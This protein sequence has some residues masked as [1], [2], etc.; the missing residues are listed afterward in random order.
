MKELIEKTIAKLNE[1]FGRRIIRRASELKDPGKISTGSLS[2]D[3]AIGGGYPRARIAEIHGRPASFKT[4]MALKVVKEFQEREEKV[5]FIDSEASLNLVWAK[6]LGVDDSRLL[7]VKPGT[8]EEGLDIME[9][10][11]RT[12]EIGLVVIDTINGLIPRAILEKSTEDQTMGVLARLINT[13]CRKVQSLL[14]ALSSKEVY[15]LFLFVNTIYWGIGGNYP[16]IETP[17]GMGKDFTAS[18]RLY[19]RRGEEIKKD[20]K[21]IGSYIIFQVKKNK[22]FRGQGTEGKIPFL[23]SGEVDL[24]EEIIEHSVKCGLV[25]RKGSWFLLE[26]NK[27]QGKEELQNYFK[28]LSE[29]EIKDWRDKILKESLK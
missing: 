20:K 15:P 8:G 14:N 1:R 3:I 19:F 7:V 9:A 25:Q 28:S 13:G 10:L 16:K 23:Y 17:G 26:E 29:E 2:L 21:A 11:V 18:I 4:T 22:V 6:K 24:L 12:G 5:L 27:F